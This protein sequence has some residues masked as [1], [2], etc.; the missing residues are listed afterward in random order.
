MQKAKLFG[1]IGAAVLCFGYIP[2]FSIY[3]SIIGYVLISVSLKYL[4]DI[5]SGKFF[6]TFLI[7]SVLAIVATILFYFKIIAIITSIVVSII[8]NN[9]IVPFTLSIALYFI[10][11]YVLIILSAY[12][13]YKSFYEIYETFNNPFFRYGALL[14]VLGAVMTIFAIGFFIQVMGWFMVLLGFFTLQ[15]VIDVDI[16]EEEKLLKN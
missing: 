4:N 9:P 1:I 5:K 6:D 14:L 11:Y 3:F 2:S 15:D 8:S 7:A 16:V 10:V 13:F 12:F